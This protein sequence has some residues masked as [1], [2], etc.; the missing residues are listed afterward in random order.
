MQYSMNSA[1]VRAVTLDLDDTL[2]PIAPVIARAEDR[3]HA[4]LVR[5][6]PATARRHDI[7]AL[8]D[9]RDAVARESV[10]IAHDFSA[11]RRESASAS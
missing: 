2:W 9:L 8:R 11:V 3:L 1:T 4:W 10:A 5:E 6:A 7:A